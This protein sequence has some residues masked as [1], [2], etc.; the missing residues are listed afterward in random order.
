LVSQTELTVSLAL[1]ASFAD[2]NHDGSYIGTVNAEPQPYIV[3]EYG[4][5]VHAENDDQL[6]PE[7]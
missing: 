7:S 6:I 3:D 2:A 4:V 5:P 1:R